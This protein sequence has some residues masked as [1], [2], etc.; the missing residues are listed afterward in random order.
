[1]SG[2]FEALSDY[3]LAWEKHDHLFL[4]SFFSDQAV[5]SIL[6][7]E[8]V[9]SGIE[10][11]ESYWQRNARRQS[12][13]KLSWSAIDSTSTR[14]TCRFIATF[15]DLE[16]GSQQCVLG[17][18]SI[19]LDDSGQIANLEEAYSKVIIPE[20]FSPRYFSHAQEVHPLCSTLIP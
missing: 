19:S 3:F 12:E 20:Q 5:Y 8:L 6:N 2:P 13:L 7:K 16:E 17:W 9:F 18:L 15:W 10:E 11:I 14:C 1:M 4:R